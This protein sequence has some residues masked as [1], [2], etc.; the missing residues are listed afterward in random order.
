MKD[1]KVKQKK[2]HRLL[3]FNLGFL[4][5][6]IVLVG[7]VGGV[8]YYAYKNI[9]PNYVVKLEEKFENQYKD[10]FNATVNNDKF[11]LDKLDIKYVTYDQIGTENHL[12]LNGY[13]TKANETETKT[14]TVTSNVSAQDYEIVK[15]KFSTKYDIQ[16]DMAYNYSALTLYNL[17][18]VF[19][20]STTQLKSFTF[21]GAKINLED[22]SA[23]ASKIEEIGKDGDIT[24]EDIVELY[25]ELKEDGTLDDYTDEEIVDI[26]VTFYNE[27]GD[28]EI[29][30]EDA[31]ELY[32]QFKNM[33]ED[34]LLEWIKE[35]T[36]EGKDGEGQGDEQN[37]SSKLGNKTQYTYTY[38]ANNNDDEY[39]F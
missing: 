28:G 27:F 39:T 24:P 19:T 15:S 6:Q 3:C 33:S 29:S 22:I 9:L 8:G 35:H 7:A 16:K 14:F 18:K 25:E 36:G 1:N 38:N 21:D 5:G 12:N 13:I 32:D 2:A 30:E 34:E 17:Y 20:S 11:K 37:K 10:E 31:Q 4:T 23:I 26:I